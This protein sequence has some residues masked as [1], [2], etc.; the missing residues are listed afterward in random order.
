MTQIAVRW[1]GVCP[2]ATP[3][4]IRH[5]ATVIIQEVA[6]RHDL[7][8]EE[9]LSNSR[10]RHIAWP[11]QEAMWEMR[12]RTKMSL[13]QIARRLGLKDHTTIHH[14]IKRHEARMAEGQVVA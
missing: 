2:E 1:H 6:R 5:P 13:P 7:T 8:V 11:R 10:E 14:G 12:Q 3:P 9:L 4:V